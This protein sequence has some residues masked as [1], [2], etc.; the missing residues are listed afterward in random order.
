MSK[1]IVAS[2][3]VEGATPVAPRRQ[4]IAAS[5]TQTVIV[6][7]SEVMAISSCIGSNSIATVRLR[8]IER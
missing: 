5:R 8:R 4:G 2:A 3:L 1:E 6:R 7:W